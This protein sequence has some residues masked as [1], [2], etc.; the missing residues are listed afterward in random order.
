MKYGY[1]KI[2]IVLLAAL[3]SFQVNA[4]T[5]SAQFSSTID[6]TY[7]GGTS[8]SVF[9]VNYRFNDAETDS[10]ASVNIGQYGNVSGT[11]Q[12]G[13]DTLS[14]SGATIRVENDNN[15][16]ATPFDSYWFDS[17]GSVTGSV[18]GIDILN[19]RFELFDLDGTAFTDDSLP[20][21]F[22]FTSD[23]DTGWR[24]LRDVTHPTGI[25]QAA[26]FSN[27]AGGEFYS[28]TPTPVPIPAAVW[29]FGTG[30]LGLLG[31]TTRRKATR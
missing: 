4:A 14:F 20:S 10:N 7:F 6:L 12:I 27:V 8:D 1:L 22:L 19:I 5:I 26:S 28:L 17:H 31:F 3:L 30:L 16:L 25:Y 18:L 2:K 23:I 15:A 21:D 9:E 11:A 29:L 24:L 13:T